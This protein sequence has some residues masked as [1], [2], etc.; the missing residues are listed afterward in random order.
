M[1]LVDLVAVALIVA[2][3]A[4]GWFT[5]T[6][7]RVIG[8][9]GVYV[10]CGAGSYFAISGAGI[11]RQYSPTI[12]I[13]DARLYA[14]FGFF[15]LIVVIFEGLATAIHAQIQV[16]AV[17]LDHAV[18]GA[19][20]ALTAIVVIVAGFYMMAGYA[21]PT[22]AN[23]DSGQI[24]VRDSLANSTVVL[25]IVKNAGE[26]ILPLLIAVLPRDSQLFFGSEAAH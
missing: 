15:A 23:I 7:R 12:Q 3:V 19:L 22:G 8:L 18:G 9:A 25:P 26:P 2:Y 20:G 14:W 24:S 11:I 1:T 17:A 10:A 13:P 4:W 16:S 6:I 21:R 5:G